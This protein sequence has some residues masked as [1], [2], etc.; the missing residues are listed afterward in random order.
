MIAKRFY[1]QILLAIGLIENFTFA[2]KLVLRYRYRASGIL[3]A[4]AMPARDCVSEF[5]GKVWAPDPLTGFFLG[6]IT[7]IGTD[8]VVVEPLKGTRVQVNIF[9]HSLLSDKLLVL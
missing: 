4:T 7:S 1:H 9:E 3:P 6:R 8:S 5:G 2:A